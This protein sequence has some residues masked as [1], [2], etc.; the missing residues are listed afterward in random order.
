V[1]ITVFPIIEVLRKEVPLNARI[2]T[3]LKRVIIKSPS[4]R[5]PKVEAEAK[6]A[7]VAIILI[8]L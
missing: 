4:Y 2:E 5:V 1:V 3:V 7:R 6:E 8:I